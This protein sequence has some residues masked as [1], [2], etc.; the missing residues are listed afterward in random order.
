MMAM[1]RQMSGL[2]DRYASGDLAV[3][4]NVGPLVAPTTGAQA[5]AGSVPPAPAPDV[6]QR[7]AVHLAGDEPRRG[8]VGLGRAHGGRDGGRVGVLGRLRRGQPRLPGGG[9]VPSPS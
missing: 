5:T 8:G 4:A 1:P 9:S 2:A 6:P 3:L 7:P